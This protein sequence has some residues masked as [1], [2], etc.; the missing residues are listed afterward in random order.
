MDP[1]TSISPQKSPSR[2]L[3]EPVDRGRG[4]GVGV[5]GLAAARS[6]AVTVSTSCGRVV[7]R[8]VRGGGEWGQLVSEAARSG[9]AYMISSCA[10][11]GGGLPRTESPPLT[12]LLSAPP[13]T[14]PQISPSRGQ[15]RLGTAIIRHS[16]AEDVS[17]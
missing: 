15:S 16:T 14:H 4:A 17:K 9:R 13:Q 5:G 12:K 10:A 8:M 6:A 3:S 1:K 2:Q 11:G 7:T